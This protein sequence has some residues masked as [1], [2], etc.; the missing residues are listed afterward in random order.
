MLAPQ[1]PQAER[2]RGG[3]GRRLLTT[4]DTLK[5]IAQATGFHG[6]FHLSRSFKNATGASPSFYRKKRFTG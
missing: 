4:D 2:A 1:T 5:E 3:S 6:A